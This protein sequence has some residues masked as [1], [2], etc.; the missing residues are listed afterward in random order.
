MSSFHAQARVST[1]RAD[2]YLAQL[3][4]HG[5]MLSRLPAHRPGAHGA[6][7]G[8]PRPR[9]VSW[10]KTEGVIDFGFGR[11]ILRATEDALSLRVEAGDPESLRQVQEGIAA[12]L[13]RIGRR[14]RLAVN[15]TEAPGEAAGQDSSPG[16]DA[17]P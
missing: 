15:W 1:D 16:E 10:S 7:G 2:R 8:P 12:R 4:S 14:D 3:G 6:G 5:S 17:R 13:Q 9:R 11:C